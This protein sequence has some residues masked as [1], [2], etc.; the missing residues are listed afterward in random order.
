MSTRTRDLA[1]K[2]EALASRIECLVDQ[3][4]ED[5]RA[6]GSLMRAAEA[7]EPIVARLEDDLSAPAKCHCGEVA[8]CEVCICCRG[9]CECK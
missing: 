3:R 7:L 2:V 9:C 4:E 1:D 8:T 5:H 6:L